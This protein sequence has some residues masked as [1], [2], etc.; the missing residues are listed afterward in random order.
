MPYQSKGGQVIFSIIKGIDHQ[1]DPKEI[2]QVVELFLHKTDDNGNVPDAH[3]LQLPDLPLDQLFTSDA[4]QG[5][6]SL[7]LNRN[8]AHSITGS[9]ENGILGTTSLYSLSR[10][11]KQ[12][13]TV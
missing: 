10:P 5:F 7:L 8:H 2:N 3:F 1:L 6:G 12:R 9:Q 13:E 4:E 11:W